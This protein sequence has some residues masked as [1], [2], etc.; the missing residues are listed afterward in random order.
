MSEPDIRVWRGGGWKKAAPD[1]A[2]A[3]VRD[4]RAVDAE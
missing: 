3:R 2:N 4:I 1:V